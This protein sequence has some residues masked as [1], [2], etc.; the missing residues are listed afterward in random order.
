MT[1]GT[2]YVIARYTPTTFTN[3]QGLFNAGGAVPNDGSDLYFTGD[4]SGTGLNW[5]PQTQMN[6]RYV[7]GK[8]Q[9][10]TI[11]NLT[12]STSIPAPIALPPHSMIGLSDATGTSRVESG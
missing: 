4:A 9:G 10:V 5:Y 11:P 3:Y 1:A 2:V 6:S 8:L 12:N 7:D